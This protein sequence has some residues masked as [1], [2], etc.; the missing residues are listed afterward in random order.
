VERSLHGANI[1]YAIRVSK[2]ARPASERIVSSVDRDAIARR[3][4]RRQVEEALEEERER[5]AVLA[6]RLEEVVAEAEG[7]RV[8]EEAFARMQAE[9]VAL[10]RD[11]LQVLEP[12][13]EGDDGFFADEHEELVHGGVADEIARLRQEIADSQRR[14]QA[15]RSYLEAVESLEPGA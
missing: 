4:R 11:V 5:E 12:L 3:Q 2:A 14:Q 10:V 1:Q 9:D 7:P 13:D 8:D 6:E 15:Y